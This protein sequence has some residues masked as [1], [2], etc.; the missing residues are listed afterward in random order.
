[1]LYI[2]SRDVYVLFDIGSTLSYVAPYVAVHYDFGLE[3]IHDPFLGS[4]LVGESIIDKR[5]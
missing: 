2:F 5:I 1:M 4:T 3:N